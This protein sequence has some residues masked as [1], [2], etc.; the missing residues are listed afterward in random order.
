MD[1]V[2]VFLVFLGI[3]IQPGGNPVGFVVR[4]LTEE[5]LEQQSV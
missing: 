5:K 1:L 2:H 4:G 3:G